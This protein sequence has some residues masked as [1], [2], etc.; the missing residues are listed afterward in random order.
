MRRVVALAKFRSRRRLCPSGCLAADQ[1]LYGRASKKTNV[2]HLAIPAGIGQLLPDKLKVIRFDDFRLETFRRHTIPL[3]S[4][5]AGLYMICP[6]P[7]DKSPLR[8]RLG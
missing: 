5:A 2:I 8:N 6:W 3:Q 4:K 7:K 1:K